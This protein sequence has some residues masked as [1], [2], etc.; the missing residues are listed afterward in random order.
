MMISGMRFI[1]EWF[2]FDG[3]AEKAAIGGGKKYQ[4]ANTEIKPRVHGDYVY[5]VKLCYYEPIN[6]SKFEV[7]F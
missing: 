7:N 3:L 2:R 5:Q 6:Y 1:E 4:R